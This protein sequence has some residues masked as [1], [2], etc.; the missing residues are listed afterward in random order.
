LESEH[1]KQP[2]TNRNMTMRNNKK[3][4]KLTLNKEAITILRADLG[5]VAG[6]YSP[7]PT[8]LGAS[9]M[10]GS[11]NACPVP[12]QNGQSCPD[13]ACYGGNAKR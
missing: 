13:T 9:G 11:C 2:I 6:G 12:S 1:L 3:T 5:G 8:V 10:Y 7:F 4:G